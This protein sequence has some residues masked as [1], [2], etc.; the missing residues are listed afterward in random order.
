MQLTV[1]VH[2][3]EGSYW[4]EVLELPGCF[5]AGATLDELVACTA[6]A[7]T[8]CISDADEDADLV[9]VPRPVVTELRMSTAPS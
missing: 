5:G 7:V 8:L 3:E 9:K 6:E 4:A 1:R 2:H